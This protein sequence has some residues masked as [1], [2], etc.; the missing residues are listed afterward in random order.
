[1]IIIY[2]CVSGPQRCIFSPFLAFAKIVYET[3]K[4][5]IE[6]IRF[7]KPP[8]S[9]TTGTFTPLG[10]KYADSVYHA[11]QKIFTCQYVLKGE[12]VDKLSTRSL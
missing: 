11:S 8:R 6:V 7:L 1:M 10:I 2:I 4:L 9:R 5:E 3:W 12:L